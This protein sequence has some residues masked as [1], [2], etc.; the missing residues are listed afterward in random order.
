MQTK[1]ERALLPLAAQLRSRNADGMKAFPT[2]A[3]YGN[4]GSLKL[5]VSVPVIMCI[6]VS[7]DSPASESH[8]YL[9][10]SD[11]E[12]DSTVSEEEYIR[13]PEGGP[14]KGKGGFSLKQKRSKRGRLGLEVMPYLALYLLLAVKD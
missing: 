9:P 8:L 10:V 12:A 13:D 5:H 1:G 11:E 4:A 2:Q 6:A 3:M 14:D 7:L